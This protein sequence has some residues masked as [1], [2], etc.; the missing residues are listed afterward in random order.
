MPK[1]AG[2]E[3]EVKEDDHL[4]G[5]KPFKHYA[6]NEDPVMVNFP[7]HLVNFYPLHSAPP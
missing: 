2:S 6:K 4:E 5:F 1:V 3:K 7:Q